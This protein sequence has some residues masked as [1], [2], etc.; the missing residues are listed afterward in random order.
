MHVVISE[1]RVLT[2]LHK[3][4]LIDD[5]FAV[6][7]HFHMADMFLNQE[8]LEATLQRKLIDCGMVVDQLSSSEMKHLV[9]IKRANP[10]LCV[11][12]SASLTLSQT[13]SYP[14]L[15]GNHGL[16]TTPQAA[17][18]GLLDICWV[19]DQLEGVI[20]LERLRSCFEAISTA[21]PRSLHCPGVAM[22][23]RRY[24]Q[25]SHVSSL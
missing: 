7:H 21:E 23:L 11:G 25:V 9:D 10:N 20:E 2:A 12:N 24:S 8:A 14:I 17:A 19:M 18:I 15:V 6:G 13:R 3:V 4:S 5:L 22:R 16:A 1:R